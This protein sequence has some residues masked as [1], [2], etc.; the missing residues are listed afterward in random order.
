VNGL[1][2]RIATRHLAEQDKNRSATTA[3]EEGAL[4]GA[5]Y[6]AKVND[7]VGVD[8]LVEHT[9]I[10]N[11]NGTKNDNRVYSDFS[12]VTTL[13]DNWNVA[14]SMTLR[15]ISGAGASTVSDDVLLNLSGGYSFDNGMKLEAGYRGS[16][17]ANNE[18]HIFGL[19]LRYEG[20][21][22]K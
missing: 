1:E 19:Q 11:F 12:V 15:D 18:T 5:T 9:H 16:N 6:V 17:E 8:V 22:G 4:V 3:A 14:T 21:F 7:N 2:Y 20:E 13:Y 10:N